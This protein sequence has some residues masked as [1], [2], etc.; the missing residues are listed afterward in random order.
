[1]DFSTIST[2]RKYRFISDFDG[3]SEI[4][5]FYWTILYSICISLSL[6]LLF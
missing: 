3:I 2:E 6:C 1:M 4:G 5:N